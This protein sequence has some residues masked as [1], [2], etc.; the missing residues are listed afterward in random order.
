MSG[1]NITLPTVNVTAPANTTYVGTQNP[2]TALKDIT[3]HA[4]LVDSI[5][6]TI[7]TAT[8]V[9][10]QSVSNTPGQ[11]AAIGTVS[12]LPLV[13]QLDG[14]DNAIPHETV[15]NLLYFRYQGGKNAVI[16]DPEKGDIGLAVFADRDISNVKSTKKQANP[17]TRRRWSYCDGIYF[18]SVI[19]SAP[20]QY[21]SFTDDT[22]TLADKNGNKMVMSSSGIAFTSSKLTNTG[23]IVAGQG[24]GDKVSIQQ[25]VHSG[26]QGGGSNT[27][28]PVAE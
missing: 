2:T 24:S 25:H 20:Q 18:G 9:Q 26:V 19:A 4:F 22:I 17:G 1:A 3:T 21:L 16:I 23:D 11:I 5:L 14:N 6:N 7:S 27:A 15:H 8:L 28:P 13:T 10:V 12:V